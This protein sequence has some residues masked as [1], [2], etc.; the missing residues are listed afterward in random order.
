[1]LAARGTDM[2]SRVTLYHIA[3]SLCSQKARLA[4]AEKGVAYT[5]RV[6]DIGP[7]MQN[8]E[9]WYVRLNPAAVVPTLVHGERVVTDSARIVRYVDAMFPGP[10]LMPEAPAARADVDALIDRVDRVAFRTLSYGSDRAPHRLLHGVVGFRIRRLERH[11]R[12][13]PD[14][15]EAYRR[16]IEDVR[17]WRRGIVDRAQV[18][19]AREDARRLLDEGQRRLTDGRAFLAGEDYTLADVVWTIAIARLR[20]LGMGA[21]VDARPHLRAWYARVRGRPSFEA[22]GVMERLDPRVVLRIAAP[23]LLPRLAAAAAAL[24]AIGAV[25]WSLQG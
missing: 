8:Y 3:P 20:T 24:L 16:K 4:L 12:R 9:P 15:A 25:L 23:F 10:S 6:V 14:L 19:A 7:R 1:M 11:L 18:E 17:D 21:E 13:N 2:A 5:G 22:A